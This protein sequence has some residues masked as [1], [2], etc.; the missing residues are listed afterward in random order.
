MDTVSGSGVPIFD[1]QDW[2][3]IEDL[4]LSSSSGEDRMKADEVRHI[5]Q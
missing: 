1:L 4:S 2:Q 3:E 5:M